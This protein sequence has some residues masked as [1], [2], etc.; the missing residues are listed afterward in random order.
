MTVRVGINGFGR[1]GRTVLR[2]LLERY[3]NQLSVA[4]INSPADVK[5]SAHLFK[6]DST[7][8]R[9][10]GSVEA[11]SGSLVVDGRPI[12]YFSERDPAK[13]PWEE[14]GVQM[15]VESSGE[16]TD[17]PE[18][19]KHLRGTVKKVLI[20]A[21]SKG[22]D[23]TAMLGI[24]EQ[25][26]DPAK[27]AI[28][29][30]AS[31]TTN[32]VALLARVLNDSFTIQKALMTTV[33]AYTNDQ[34]L[35]DGSHRDLR[36]AR[37]AAANIIPTTTGA[38][39]SVGVVIPSLKGRMNGLALRVPVPDGSL[40]DFVAVLGRDVTPQEVNDA[41]RKAAAGHLKGLLDVTEEELV[42]SDFV[43]NPASCIVDLPSTMVVGG[44]LVKVLGWYDNEWGYSCRT[45]D[46]AAYIAAKGL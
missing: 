29:S 31:C 36:R 35:L 27:H 46:L 11:L 44:N 1:T 13:V 25:T 7:Y 41:Y 40:T 26:Y 28:V 43:G 33:H 45:A 16:F 39:R 3:P 30:N 32:C 4:A 20:S 38:A 42:S 19:A 24:N 18:A 34:R 14:V 9:F 8:G 21:P 22:E 17:G 15:V 6:H 23:L 5:A 10:P 37:S 12:A 2:A